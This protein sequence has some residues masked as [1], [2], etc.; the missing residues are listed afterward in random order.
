VRFPCALARAMPA[1]TRSPISALSN[2]DRACERNG[3]LS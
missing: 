1:L 2:W 3:V